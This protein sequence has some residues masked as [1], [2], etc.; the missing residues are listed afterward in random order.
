[1]GFLDTYSFNLASR[2]KSQLFC[3]QLFWLSKLSYFCSRAIH[4]IVMSVL[5][6]ERKMEKY[7]NWILWH[8]KVQCMSSNRIW[9]YFGIITLALCILTNAQSRRS[10]N[11]SFSQYR[12]FQ[13]T[14]FIFQP[15]RGRKRYGEYF[16]ILTGDAPIATD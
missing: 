4:T 3:F 5:S 14:D 13:E 7:N 11:I 10:E 15:G 2:H 6:F 12:I 8:W 1:M 16:P 9:Q